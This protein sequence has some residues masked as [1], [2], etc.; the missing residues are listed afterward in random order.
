MYVSATVCSWNVIIAAMYTV[1][2]MTIIR[3]CYC[4]FYFYTTI[5]MAIAIKLQAAHIATYQYTMLVE[6][7]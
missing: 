7:A 2:I 1:N 3:S 5:H 6:P 4:N